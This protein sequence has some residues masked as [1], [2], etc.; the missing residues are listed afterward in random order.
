MRIA[1]VGK[2]NAGKSSLVNKLLGYDRTIV[3]DIAGTTRDSIDTP[4]TINDKKYVL[5]DTA[6]IRKKKSVFDDVEYYSVVRA[7]G[8]IRKAD[9][10]LIVVDATEGLTEQD[11]KICGYVH[12][13]GKPSVIVMNKWDLVDK[14]TNTI[15]EFEKKLA[16]DLAFMDYFKS[17]YISA[18]SGQRVEK[19][20]SVAQTVYENSQKRISTGLLNDVL[21]DAIRTTDPPTKHGRRLKIYYSTQDGVNPPTFIIFVNNA[22]LMHFSYLRFLENIIR[23]ITDFSG[24]PIRLFV[25]EKEQE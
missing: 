3:S 1:V 14:D 20:L 10:V 22:E 8:S 17:I 16:C 13:Q 23:K 12:E 2:P 5:V 11:T 9:V 4:F 6:G 25:R 18:K 19:V 15:N 24:T 7:L 21:G